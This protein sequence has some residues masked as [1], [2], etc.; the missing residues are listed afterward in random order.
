MTGHDIMIAATQWEIAHGS[1]PQVVG[2]AKQAFPMLIK[3]L[4]IMRTAA[5]VG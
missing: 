2:L 4:K 5:A 1:S 3:H